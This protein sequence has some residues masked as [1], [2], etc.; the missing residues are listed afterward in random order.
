MQVKTRPVNT[1]PRGG[2]LNLGLLAALVCCLAV[3]AGAVYLLV[4]L[5]G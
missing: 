2:P 5:T 3:W 1:Q 4:L